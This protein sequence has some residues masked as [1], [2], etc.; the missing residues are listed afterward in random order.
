MDETSH[1][2]AP[3]NTSQTFSL[4]Q[5]C[6]F[7]P[8]RDLAQLNICSSCS[9][10]SG[11]AAAA[12]AMQDCGHITLIHMLLLPESRLLCW[13]VPKVPGTSSTSRQTC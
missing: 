7:D 4:K 10:V 11:A 9:S 2:L 8:R 1:T 6:Y 3:I 12:A 5:A 13:H